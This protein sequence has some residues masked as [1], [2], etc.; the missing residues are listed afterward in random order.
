MRI[1]DE[2][3]EKSGPK[4]IMFPSGAVVLLFGDDDKHH[5]G[6]GHEPGIDVVRQV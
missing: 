4:V 5:D 6:Y 2:A 3:N 1:Y